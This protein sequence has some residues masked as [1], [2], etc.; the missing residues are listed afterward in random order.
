MG[1]F[2]LSIRS[3]LLIAVGSLHLSTLLATGYRYENTGRLHKVYLHKIVLNTDNLR[4]ETLFKTIFKFWFH[5]LCRLQQHRQ[6][7]CK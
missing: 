3:T 4:G 6:T 5:F 1:F 2:S 7:I